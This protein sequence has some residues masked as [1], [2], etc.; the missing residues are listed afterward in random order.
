MGLNVS[1]VFFLSC[2]LILTPDLV[3]GAGFPGEDD[4]GGLVLVFLIQGP[5]KFRFK[6]TDKS[7]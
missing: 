2:D 4:I 1:R 6:T 5:P 3:T 7:S